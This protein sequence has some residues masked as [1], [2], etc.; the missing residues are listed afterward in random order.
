MRYLPPSKIRIGFQ[1]Q[2]FDM[3]CTNIGVDFGF[4]KFV[5]ASER[6]TMFVHARRG[7]GTRYIEHML[8]TSNR[9]YGNQRQ[10]HE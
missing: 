8:E 5:D 7:D 9:L 1:I 3:F 6:P 4:R 2:I 10:I